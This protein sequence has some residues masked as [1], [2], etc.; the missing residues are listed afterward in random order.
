MI[1]LNFSHP[2]T[3]TPLARL[4]ELTA[5]RIERGG[6]TTPPFDHARPVRETGA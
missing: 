6:K 3:P 5:V 2:L 1:V 4:A